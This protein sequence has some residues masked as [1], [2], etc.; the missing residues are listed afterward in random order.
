[1]VETEHTPEKDQPA[2]ARG[3]YHVFDKVLLAFENGPVYRALVIFGLAA[4]I[5]GVW[6]QVNE[7]RETKSIWHQEALAR[8]WQVLAMPIA[9]NGGK[10][11][12][13][14][15]LVA[16]GES[17]AGL[18]LS[19]STMS[20][21]R[22]DGDCMGVDLQFL[23]LSAAHASNSYST[24]YSGYPV[25]LQRFNLSGGFVFESTISDANLSSA[26]WDHVWIQNTT[27]SNVWAHRASFHQSTSIDIQIQNSALEFANFSFSS[28]HGNIQRTR[29]TG[30]NFENSLLD[31]LIF[32]DVELFGANFRS[33]NLSG[34]VFVDVL[35][36]PNDVSPHFD[37]N[38]VEHGGFSRLLGD[39]DFEGAWYQEGNPP[40][41]LPE[42]ILANLLV[43]DLNI[44]IENITQPENNILQA[45]DLSTCST[46]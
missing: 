6:W 20:Q 10:S 8:S 38:A 18:D 5:F 16:A 35:L 4:T 44:S 34:T 21:H 32:D 13:L 25:D 40:T 46:A 17:L 36:S 14:N 2:K 22:K 39:A 45:F 1:M 28:L 31:N 29:M 26:T 7:W 9:G 33:A 27:L 30:A 37:G 12:A 23:N 11:N 43:C 19:C 42:E 3:T 24:Y 41:G 15:Y